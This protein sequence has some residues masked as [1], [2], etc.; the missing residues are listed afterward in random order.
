[1]KSIGAQY[2]LLVAITTFCFGFFSGNPTPLNAQNAAGNGGGSPGTVVVQ[3]NQTPLNQTTCK[4]E[5][6]IYCLLEPL[7]IGNAGAELSEIKPSEVFG[8]YVTII[9]KI[10][11]G[12]TGALAVIYIIVG[13]IEYMTT[14]AFSRKESG[15]ETITRSIFGLIIGLV[16]VLLL[17]TINPQLTAI[18][19][20]VQEVTV[21]AQEDWQD[22]TTPATLTA[23]NLSS[24]S[25]RAVLYR[26]GMRDSGSVCQ[27]GLGGPDSQKITDLTSQ[28]QTSKNAGNFKNLTTLNVPVQ[29]SGK[30]TYKTLADKLKTFTT[31]YGSS[32]FTVTE[33]WQPSSN[34][35]C[36]R[37]HYLGTCVDI[38]FVGI[39]NPTKAQIESFISKA[40]TA[41]LIAQFEVKTKEEY[42]AIGI[43]DGSVLVASWVS[44]NHFSVY[45]RQ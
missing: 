45:D 25:Q 7:P 21:V 20:N 12:V 42:E 40:A 15:K 3:G 33:A 16:A 26:N 5:G 13:G 24:E 43:R 10:T 27:Q 1:M 9:I 17:Y 4:E 35:H 6:G 8:K 32:N 14:D 2:L 36:A 39:S 31:S 23:G 29:A 28:A 41:G 34:A 19:F 18:V 38:D 22:G 11:I 37:C 30:F 44:G